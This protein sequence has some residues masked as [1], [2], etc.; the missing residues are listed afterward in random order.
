MDGFSSLPPEIRLEILLFLKTRSNI[1][2]LLRASPT[3]L[4]QYCESKKHIRRAFL[5]AELDGSVLQDALGVVLFP[6]YDTPRVNFNAVKR[7]VERSSLAQFRDPFRHND[8][9]TVECLDRLY[10]RLSTYI[11]D[12]VTKASSEYPP[13]A[14]M[15]LPDLSSQRGVLEFRNNAIGINVIK[16]DDLSDAE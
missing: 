13:R 2:P 5:R 7:H 6:L 12:Y 3:M 15:G 9:D 16:M 10:D 14:Y 8:H 1:L 4:A 11:E